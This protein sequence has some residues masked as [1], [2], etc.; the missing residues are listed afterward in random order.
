MRGCPF[1]DWRYG[2]KAGISGSA[3]TRRCRW[4][5]SPASRTGVR[6]CGRSLRARRHGPCAAGFLRLIWHRILAWERFPAAGPAWRR[7]AVDP[8]LCDL[9]SRGAWIRSLR[10]YWV[11][12]GLLGVTGDFIGVVIAGSHSFH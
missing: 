11:L 7:A 4:R 9:L 3:A 5:H 2:W 6:C 10:R 1:Q 8:D 12:L